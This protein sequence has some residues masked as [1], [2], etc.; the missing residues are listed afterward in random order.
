ME[1]HAPSSLDESLDFQGETHQANGMIFIRLI[2]IYCLAPLF[3]QAA[4]TLPVVDLDKAFKVEAIKQLNLEYKVGESSDLESL[5][6][7]NE[8]LKQRVSDLERRLSA[9]EARLDEKVG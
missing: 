1:Q 9:I 6:K 2:L 5:R 8:L 4:E 7:E 3:L